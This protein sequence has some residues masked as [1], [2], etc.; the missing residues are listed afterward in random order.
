MTSQDVIHSFYV[1]AFRLKYDVIPGRYTNLHF[2][3]TQ[4][5]EYHIFC[6]EYCGTGHSIMRGRV[7]VVEPRE[8]QEWLAGGGPE[9]TMVASG[10]QLFTQLGCVGCHRPDTAERAP[11]LAGRFGQ[12][13][14]LEGG[15]TVIFDENYIRS[16]ILFPQR[17]ITAGYEPLMPSYEGRINEEQLVQLVAFIKGLPAGPAGPLEGQERI[18]P[19]Q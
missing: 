16:S 8:Y 17:H 5:G 6:T 2:E 3:A 10:E 1:P 7:I 13:V 15:E 12:P 4:T 11:I 18:E 19:E 9:N 14:L